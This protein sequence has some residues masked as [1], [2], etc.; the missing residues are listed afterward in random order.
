M[1]RMKVGLGLLSEG[2]MQGS[3]QARKDK[4]RLDPGDYCHLAGLVPRMGRRSGVPWA[5]EV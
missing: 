3:R 4:P 5:T 1:L 2:R